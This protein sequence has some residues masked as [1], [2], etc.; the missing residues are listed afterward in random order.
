MTSQ[1]GI[2]G[3]HERNFLISVEPVNYLKGHETLVSPNRRML[4][5]MVI[6]L[7]LAIPVSGSMLSSCGTLLHLQLEVNC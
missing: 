2:K 5:Y 4:F 6:V 1:L 3:L 7:Y